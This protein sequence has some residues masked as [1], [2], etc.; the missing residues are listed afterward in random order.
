M[1]KKYKILVAEDFDVIREDI[2]E[3]IQS[4]A[5]M[6]VVGEAVSG[7][8][9]V[10]LAKKTEY[11]II[12]MDIEMEHMHSGIQATYEIMDGN[13]EAKIIFLTAHETKQMII[14]AMGAGAVDYIVKGTEDEEILKHIRGVIKGNSVMQQKIQETIMQEY[15]RLQKSERSLLFFINNIS[16]LTSAER[17]LIKLLLEG[18]KVN[19]IAG[20]RS[21]ETS[22]IKTQI[23]RLLRK[24][25]C[26]RSKEI[27]SMIR[28]MNIEH[29]FH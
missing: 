26:E 24:F 3:L 11:D 20:I 13:P 4:Q 5:D 28:D 23:N 6:T 9:I 27:V 8:E 25:G 10:E 15:V 7:R 21:V 17:D 22:T 19:E 16:K 1:S 2:V 18:H 12:L 14:N 29:L